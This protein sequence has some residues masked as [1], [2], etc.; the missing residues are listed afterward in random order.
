MVN[1]E[2]DGFPGTLVIPSKTITTPYLKVFV[3]FTEGLENRIF[4]YDSTLRPKKDRRGLST[5]IQFSTNWDEKIK[6]KRQKD[7]I[8]LRYLKVFDKMLT[9]TIDT[10][11]VD[12]DFLMTVER[13][14][15][16]FE[17]YL[18]LSKVP[19][20]KNLLKAYRRSL[21]EQDTTSEV[22]QTIPYWKLRE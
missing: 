14:R 5:S 18:D 22:R 13:E 12:G 3:P 20:G 15:M 7:S 9:F 10:L 16:G 21:K 1:D 6:S 17:T 19:E 4:Q 8:R 11:K 2:N